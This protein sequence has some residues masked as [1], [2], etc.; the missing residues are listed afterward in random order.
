MLSIINNKKKLIYISEVFLYCIVFTYCGFIVSRLLDNFMNKVDKKINNKSV[1]KK[2][3]ITFL[4]IGLIGISCLLIR[5]VIV[6]I[7]D[8]VLG[9]TWGNPA[10]YATVILGSIMFSNSKTIHKNIELIRKSY[11]L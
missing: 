2:H 11:N 5:E 10:T 3:L 1:V 4:H 6:Y 7:E 8:N 9:K